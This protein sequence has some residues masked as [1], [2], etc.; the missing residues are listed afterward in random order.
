MITMTDERRFYRFPAFDDETG[1]KLTKKNKRKLFENDFNDSYKYS[2]NYTE[3]IEFDTVEYQDYDGYEHTSQNRPQTAYHAPQSE[4]ANKIYDKQEDSPV[5]RPGSPLNT[6]YGAHNDGGTGFHS[7]HQ[8]PREEAP[9]RFRPKYIPASMIEDDSLTTY[10]QEQIISE[11][12]KNRANF[13]L[14]TDTDDE[15]D[16]PAYFS[17]SQHNDVP[18]TRSEFKKQTKDT[19]SFSVDKMA[20]FIPKSLKGF[21]NKQSDAQQETAYFK[22][23]SEEAA[24]KRKKQ[25]L[26]KSLSGIIANETT[27][28][29]NNFYFE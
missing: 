7:S 4:Y 29:S 2:T 20:S 3:E 24:D 1:V 16:N 22:K 27:T 15:S 19:S 9:K 8:L 5:I 10:S 18:M 28:H 26:D 25:R 23:H 17:K 21:G 6:R 11:L 14:A 13:S 12:R